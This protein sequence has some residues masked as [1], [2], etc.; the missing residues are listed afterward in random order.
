M[1][2]NTRTTSGKVGLQ[3]ASARY[4]EEAFPSV[5]VVIPTYNCAQSISETIESVLSQDYP[6][7]ELVVIDGGS[8]DQT[9]EVVKS[10]PRNSL[11]VYSVGTHQRYEML[12]IGL[13]HA[14]GLYLNFLF[15]GDFYLS[16][17]TVRIL[18][19]LA[20]DHHKPHLVYCGAVLR[21]ASH[22]VK[23]LYRPL[24]LELIKLGRQ[25][26]SLQSCWIRADTFHLVG[27]F[28]S[29]YSLRG[30]YDFLCRF[31]LKGDL[32][33]VSIRRALTD[34]DLRGVGRRAIMVH[35]WET[36]KALHKYFGWKTAFRWLCI[37][38]DTTRFLRL[39]RRSIR[40]ALF[41]HKGT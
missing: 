27:K 24:S 3:A 14:N 15:P 23:M 40:L 5:S 33:F 4:S 16:P 34:Y 2:A 37:Q 32:R 29:D 31:L 13:S 19:E 10:F 12:N 11:H 8:T 7:L 6:D 36:W 17:Q 30:G 20:L 38:K 39:W 35:F 28:P 9:L 22:D 26:T 18:M 41:G 1:G 21:E 25:P